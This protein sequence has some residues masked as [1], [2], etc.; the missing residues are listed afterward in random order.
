[1]S[2]NKKVTL[3]DYPQKQREDRIENG[4]L[5]KWCCRPGCWHSTSGQ[6]VM[7]VPPETGYGFFKGLWTVV[8]PLK[9]P[10]PYMISMLGGD[11]EE[12][13]AFATAETFIHEQPLSSIAA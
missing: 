2:K 11:D 1:M 5:F 13:R 7:V 8:V 6:P 12:S 9:D 4:H 3:F 10:A